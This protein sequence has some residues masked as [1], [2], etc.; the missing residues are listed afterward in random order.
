MSLDIQ[1]ILA[2]F[3][4]IFFGIFFTK[5]SKKYLMHLLLVLPL[6]IDERLTYRTFYALEIESARN[7]PRVSIRLLPPAE[8]IQA[9][10]AAK[11]AI[12]QSILK[13]YKVTA[14]NTI[15]IAIKFLSVP[16]IVCLALGQSATF[17]ATV[18]LSI[19]GF[20]VGEIAPKFNNDYTQRYRLNL[21]LDHIYTIYNYR[22][23]MPTALSTSPIIDNNNYS[24]HKQL[25]K[26]V[27]NNNYS[28]ESKHIHNINISW[29]QL[30]WGNDL[31][32]C[33]L[34]S[35]FYIFTSANSFFENFIGVIQV[36]LLL[37]IFFV[38]AWAMITT[39]AKLVSQTN[40][41][42]INDF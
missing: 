41:S 30:W 15:L 29:Q 12:Q 39:C 20:F 14:K 19:I 22:K 40:N 18:I 3:L 24:Q 32:L 36:I 6:I 1:A 4:G 10:N 17:L 28:F 11:P 38:P 42:K 35:I 9:I 31:I 16:L 5:Q 37:Q 7:N 27:I 8:H 21:L 13:Q 33:I 25:N 26:T 23:Q 2:L 34:L